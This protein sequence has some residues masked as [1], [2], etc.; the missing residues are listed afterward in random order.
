MFRVIAVNE[1]G[2]GKPSKTVDVV[3]EPKREEQ[4][5]EEIAQIESALQ[6]RIEEESKPTATLKD[7][8]VELTW[9]AMENV[10]LYAIERRSSNNGTWVQIAC[11]DRNWFVDRTIKEPGNYSYRVIAHFDGAEQKYSEPTN[12]VSVE[13]KDISADEDDKLEEHVSGGDEMSPSAKLTPEGV[14]VKWTAIGNVKLYAIERRKSGD[15]IWVQLDCV[16]FNSFVDQTI[17]EPGQ[18]VYRVVAQLKDGSQLISSPTNKVRIEESDLRRQKDIDGELDKTSAEQADASLNLVGAKSSVEDQSANAK[19][20]K[21]PEAKVLPKRRGEQ[22]EELEEDVQTTRP[23]EKSTIDDDDVENLDRSVDRSVEGFKKKDESE[24][25]GKTVGLKSRQDDNVGFGVRGRRRRN[26]SDQENVEL[27]GKG[28]DSDAS[29]KRDASPPI[30]V[31]KI[32][33]K[34]EVLDSPTELTADEE[35]E[36]VFEFKFDQL[37]EGITISWLKDG[38]PL[39]TVGR[40]KFQSS[41]E[42]GVVRLK[43]DEGDYSCRINFGD[44]PLAECSTKLDVKKKIAEEPLVESSSLLEPVD[45]R[46]KRVKRRALSDIEPPVPLRLLRELQDDEVKLGGSTTLSVTYSSSIVP[47]FKF[48]KNGKQIINLP[49]WYTIKQ[50]GGRLLCTIENATLDDEGEWMLVVET[51]QSTIETKCRIT[52]KVPP[53]PVEIEKPPAHDAFESALPAITRIRQRLDSETSSASSPASKRLRQIE[54][55]PKERGEPPKFHHLL[56]D[57]SAREGEHVILSVTSTTIPEPNVQW[58]RSGILIERTNSNYII[59]VETG[60]FEF[61]ILSCSKQDNAEWMAVGETRF[62]RCESKCVLTVLDARRQ[63][64]PYFTIGLQNQTC[65]LGSMM[66]LEV[67]V[68]GIPD[69]DLQWFKNE[70]LLQH[71]SEYRIVGNNNL[72]TLTILEAAKTHAG[73]YEVVAEN[74]AGKARTSCVVTVNDPTHGSSKAEETQIPIVRMPLLPVREIPEGTELNLVCTITGSPLPKIEWQKDDQAVFGAYFRY[75]NGVATMT[76]L[77]AE[78]TH[79]GVY[80]AIGSNKFGSTR[81]SCVL[82]VKPSADSNRTAPKFEDPLTNVS[83]LTGKE[84]CLECRVVCKPQSSLKLIWYKDGIKMLPSNRLLQYVD[85]RGVVRLNLMD[86]RL[87]DAGEYGVQAENSLGQDFTHCMVRITDASTRKS[88]AKALHYKP[89]SRAPLVTR[90]LQ[91]CTVH[92]GNQGLLEC[93]VQAASGATAEWTQNGQLLAESRTLRS[94]FDGRLALLKIFN[95]DKSHEGE[96]QLFI[97]DKYGQTTSNAMLIESEGSSVSLCCEV[98]G[99][100]TPSLIWLLNGKTLQLSSE[101]QAQIDG[102]THTLSIYPF[103][104]K[105]CGTITAIAKNIYGEV[106]SSTDIQLK[107]ND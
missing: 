78:L 102:N 50:D 44:A 21:K 53:K 55:E 81:T 76:I 66:I 84:L 93:E 75:D 88:S 87:E 49:G 20:K 28:S 39:N 77:R 40:R 80:T 61:E 62:G 34:I 22:L 37:P 31:P 58:Y 64:E 24:D 92:V 65:S 33:P 19:I 43:D 71:G 4:V 79:S 72:N 9:K 60:R 16:R 104:S 90:P 3:T 54:E 69:P 12:E 105:Y 73:M 35:A 17:K 1:V 41:V 5:G 30:V 57:L 95:A 18:Y 47:E 25:A 26:L 7:N 15:S 36:A 56:E 94:Y 48:F 63:V 32:I 82:Y 45:F 101:I 107:K 38:R 86:C 98:Q 42:D 70:Q 96:Y 83:L 10:K 91:D 14:E 85:R 29:A 99:L 103:G 67:N 52:V 74:A 2:R 46:P 106:H 13:E 51:P 68:R 59:K 89:D 6:E 11:T 23:K 8:G 97:E 27:G 100:P